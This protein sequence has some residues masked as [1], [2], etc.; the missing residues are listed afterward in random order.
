[1][2]FIHISS[3][4]RSPS[5]QSETTH[6][7][8]PFPLFTLCSQ[9]VSCDSTLTMSYIICLVIFFKPCVYLDHNSNHDT[10]WVSSKLWTIIIFVINVEWAPVQ[11]IQIYVADWAMNMFCHLW[12][13]MLST[14]WRLNTL[15][16]LWSGTMLLE[17]CL[18]SEHLHERRCLLELYYI[19]MNVY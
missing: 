2:A 17:Q 19:H 4:L 16:L 14:E 6:F 3:H 9:K 1:M 18:H 12:L 5:T 7:F 13:I 11:W 8:I 10:I 15:W